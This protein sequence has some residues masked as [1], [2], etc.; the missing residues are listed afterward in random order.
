MRLR[1][2]RVRVALAPRSEIVM[3]ALLPAT[4]FTLFTLF[5]L[6]EFDDVFRTIL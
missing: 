2:P 5:A 6:R 1:L 3:T 4:L